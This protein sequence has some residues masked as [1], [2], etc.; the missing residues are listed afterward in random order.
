MA[1]KKSRNAERD[2]QE[3]RKDRLKKTHRALTKAEQALETNLVQEGSPDRTGMAQDPRLTRVPKSGERFSMP[4]PKERAERIGLDPE[5]GE[6]AVEWD[7]SPIVDVIAEGDNSFSAQDVLEDDNMKQTVAKAREA[8]KQM[9]AD[10]EDQDL[11]EAFPDAVEATFTESKKMEELGVRFVNT[12]RLRQIIKESRK[13]G[14]NR[15]GYNDVELDELALDGKH[16]VLP[17]MEHHFANGKPVDTHLRTTIYGWTKTAARGGDKATMNR[18]LDISYRSFERLQRAKKK[19]RISPPPQWEHVL[20]LY[21][22]LYME[23]QRNPAMVGWKL[24]DDEEHQMSLSVQ[25]LT[26]LDPWWVSSETM[27]LVEVAMDKMPSHELAWADLLT[28]TG[29]AVLERPIFFDL[30][31]WGEVPIIAVSWKPVR[32]QNG[33]TEMLCMAW[34]DLEHEQSPNDINAPGYRSRL[35]PGVHFT[36]PEGQPVDN[37]LEWK[38]A[39][40][41]MATALLE[42]RKFLAAMWLLSQQQVVGIAGKK[43]ARGFRRMAERASLPTTVK[44]V[45][46][47]RAMVQT[48]EGGEPQEVEWSHR[49]LVSGHWRRIWSEKEQRLRTVWVS[50][51]IKGPA[52]KPLIIKDSFYRFVR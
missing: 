48:P 5:T 35:W 23:T 43:P 49:W 40:E 31:D 17:F 18:T 11:I 20:Q 42:F 14:Y 27:T 7:G 30:E 15:L 28:L 41:T 19:R 8:A 36:W 26:G 16:L 38:N 12:R 29:F 32:V 13:L 47:R 33:H 51:Y 6:A 44:V 45:T 25:E 34:I 39:S 37:V 1:K 21:Y 2:Y 50:P 52:S 10:S 4:Q 46:L 22:D 24:G 9:V 3:S